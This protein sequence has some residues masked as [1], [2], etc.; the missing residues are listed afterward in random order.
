[1]KKNLILIILLFLLACASE[2]KL[3]ISKSCP[4]VNFSKNHRVYLSSEKTQITLDNINY[5]ARLNNYNFDTS[6]LLL[7]NN[8][9]FTLSLLFVVQPEKVNKSKIEMPY[10]VAILDNQKNIIDQQ[11]YVADGNLNKSVDNS[12]YI[13]SE[14][15]DFVEINIPYSDDSNSNEYQILIGFML[16]AD[17]LKI[18]N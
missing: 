3:L 1:V 9:N 10:F 16:S 17:K 5:R 14:I 13:E 2:K 15:I 12:F 18:L 8:L 11:Y 4:E 7:N 6:C